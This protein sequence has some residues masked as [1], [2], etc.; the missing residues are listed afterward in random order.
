[1]TVLPT[2]AY[3]F[4]DAHLGFAPPAVAANVLSFLRYLRTTAGSVVINGDLFEFWFEWKTV[5]PRSSFRV[6]SALADLRDAGIPVVMVAG[7]H[8][9]WGGDVLRNDVGVDYR[10]DGWQGSIGGWTTRIEHGDGLRPV[11]DRGYRAIKPI[12]RS[13]LAMR[14]FRWLPPDLA[15]ALAGGSSNA[16]RTYASRDRGQGL[17]DIARRVFAENGE[18]DLLVYGHSHTAMLERLT[19]T[20][21]YANS[22]SWLDAPQFLRITAERVALREWS[23]STESADLHA[24]DRAAKEPLTKL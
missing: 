7:N 11:E 10:L 3:I 14:A 21:V 8:D 22:G 1:V 4:S 12:L 24:F 19:A 6:L 20:Q 9:C 23:G 18:I 5:I 2:P 17:Q 15:T 16:S 13:P